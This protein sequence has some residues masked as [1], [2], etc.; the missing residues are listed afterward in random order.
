MSLPS[1][2][3]PWR[4][5]NFFNSHFAGPVFVRYTIGSCV[6]VEQS[7]V[8]WSSTGNDIEAQA[9]AELETIAPKSGSPVAFPAASWQF[10]MSSTLVTKSAAVPTIAKS[11]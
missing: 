3:A 9:S 8:A 2:N 7:G 1:R 6:T 4:P 5:G 10:T 11:C